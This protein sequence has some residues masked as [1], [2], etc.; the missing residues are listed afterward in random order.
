M[1]HP[2]ANDA[3]TV[4]NVAASVLRDFY[5]EHDRRRDKLVVSMI[6]QED[7]VLGRAKMAEFIKRGPKPDSAEGHIDRIPPP[8]LEEAQA[9]L[10][11]ARARQKEFEAEDRNIPRFS[12][13]HIRW[14][15]VTED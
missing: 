6:I 12:I 2:N 13:G 15:K 7:M 1:L 8:S 14:A 10:E 5:D 11:A 4:A 3:A 9:D